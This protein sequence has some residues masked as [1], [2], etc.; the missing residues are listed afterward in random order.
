M[1]LSVNIYNIG[2]TFILNKFLFMQVLFKSLQNLIWICDR[3]I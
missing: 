1:E 3:R 2:W